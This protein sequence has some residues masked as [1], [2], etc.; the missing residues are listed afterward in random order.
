VVKSS[1][2]LPN[3]VAHAKLVS[4]APELADALSDLV[5]AVEAKN[6]GDYSGSICVSRAVSLLK[7]IGWYDSS[8]A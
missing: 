6:N 8:P 4:L 3:D 2:D 7:Q 1:N 5:N